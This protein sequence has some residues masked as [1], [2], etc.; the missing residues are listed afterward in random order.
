MAEPSAVEA[1]APAAAPVEPESPTAPVAPV[2]VEPEYVDGFWRLLALLI[3]GFIIYLLTVIL[4]IILGGIDF[5][6]GGPIP[7]EDIICD[8][9]KV[10][11]AYPIY[12]WLLTGQWGQTLGKEVV[13]VRVV[14]AWGYPP[15]AWRAAVRELVV[16]PLL[17]LLVFGPLLGF[18]GF[19]ALT[20]AFGGDLE[21]V[22]APLWLVPAI[23]LV[24]MYGFLRM[25]D[26]PQRR[27]WHD[28]LCGTYVVRTSWRLGRK[29]PV[30]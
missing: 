11:V 20:L 8:P 16:K 13:G 5:L 21:D 28:Q 12:F 6:R 3:D 4:S 7:W 26:H 9:R 17:I 10:M 15:G 27:G 29:I 14:E 18:L 1:P 19:V 24:G 23:G 22:P 2:E 25:P 30:N